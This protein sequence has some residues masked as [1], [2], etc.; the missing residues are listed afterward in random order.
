[1]KKYIK[2]FIVL[3]VF[4]LG[5][6]LEDDKDYPV[7]APFAVEN[8]AATPGDSEVTLSWDINGAQTITDYEITYP[9][10]D[11]ILL[12]DNQDTYTITDLKVGEEYT[13]TIYAKNGEAKSPATTA[14][15][16]PFGINTE[17]AGFISFDFLMAINPDMALEDAD[18]KDLT[19]K[20]DQ[21]ENTVTFSAD[22][23]S[24]YIYIDALIPTF[25]VPEG[26]V[27]TV[28]GVEQ[29]SGETVQDFTTTVLYSVTKD[30][31]E[32]I[33]SV[34]V[35]K[36]QYATIP[37]VEFVA[38][39]KELGMPFDGQDQ[40]DITHDLVVNYETSG[41]INLDGDG[42]ATQIQNLK[43]IEFFVNVKEIDCE[44][45]NITSLD[46]R[47]NVGMKN[48]VAGGQ[49]LSSLNFGDRTDLEILYLNSCDLS[50]EILQPVVTANS[51][52]RRLYIHG[53]DITQIDVSNQTAL[54][55][56][57]ISE[58]AAMASAAY[59]NAMLSKN[60]PIASSLG[61]L[62]VYSDDGETRCDNYDPETYQCQ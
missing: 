62:R 31:N 21:T 15:A 32:R 50:T 42:K 59:I 58:T 2:T 28:D 34:N 45:N 9:G 27:V 10:A 20:L 11:A 18:K 49:P 56:L 6:C 48:L 7:L 8:F 54:E 41:K 1:M 23:I 36:S 16:T 47:R 43:G 29:I 25:E 51:G 38:R 3:A 12:P 17:G 14:T 52:L 22:D 33:Y 35:R 44:R 19:G 55:R 53:S 30:D 24:A 40:L 60:P 46:L 13:F 4:A 61:D 39:L 37:D 5:G 26:A 57:R